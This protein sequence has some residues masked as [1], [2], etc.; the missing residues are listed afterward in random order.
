MTQIRELLIVQVACDA[1][2]FASGSV[3]EVE[4]RA[5]KLA[6]RG[7]ER[8]ASRHDAASFEYGPQKSEQREREQDRERR[9]RP[10]KRRFRHGKRK[11][12][13]RRRRE[14]LRKRARGHFVRARLQTLHRELRVAR[15]L[16]FDRLALAVRES[17]RILKLLR[18]RAAADRGDI[19]QQTVLRILEI[20]PCRDFRRRVYAL[21]EQTRH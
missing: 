15:K 5:R 21:A 8:G 3:C 10:R 14:I 16:L 12:Q 11:R 4:T 6:V 1:T 18:K 19:E 2:A 9:R 20:Q 13:R 17:K 7:N